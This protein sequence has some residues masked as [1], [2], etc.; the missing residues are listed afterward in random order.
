MTGRELLSMFANCRGI[1]RQEIEQTVNEAIKNL[2]L[3]EYADKLCG[4]Y[5][6]GEDSLV[7]P[8]SYFV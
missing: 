6:G 8:L 3:D 4:S 5:S 1:P 7:P 2:N